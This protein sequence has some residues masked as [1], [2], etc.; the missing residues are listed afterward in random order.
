MSEENASNES[1][2]AVIGGMI[3]FDQSITN[4][5]LDTA[6]ESAEDWATRYE[7]LWSAVMLVN[8]DLLVDEVLWTHGSGDLRSIDHYRKMQGK[9]GLYEN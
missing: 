3:A 9:P 7:E 4:K 1:V 2:G 8:R 6:W 5:L